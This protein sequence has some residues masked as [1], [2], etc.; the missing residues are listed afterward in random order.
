MV[1]WIAMAC[2]EH[3]RKELKKLRQELRRA[4]DETEKM[5]AALRDAGLL[6]LWHTN[7]D[8]RLAHRYIDKLYR[9]SLWRA[10][11]CKAKRVDSLSHRPEQ[12]PETIRKM[13]RTVGARAA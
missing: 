10:H 6:L 13:P 7:G 12:T 8:M 2:G 11:Q 4:R 1:A 3:V 9:D 5:S